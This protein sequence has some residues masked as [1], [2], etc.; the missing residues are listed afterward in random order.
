MVN[1]ELA[2]EPSR[3]IAI[4]DAQLAPRAVA[5]GVDRGLGHAELPRDLLGAQ[6]LIDQAQAFALSRRQEPDRIHGCDRTYP[7]AEPS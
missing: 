1:V 6:V 5:V 4:L 7:H 2:G 3:R